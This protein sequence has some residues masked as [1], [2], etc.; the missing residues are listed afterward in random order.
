METKLHWREGGRRSWNTKH[1]TQRPKSVKAVYE[2]YMDSSCSRFSRPDSNQT[3]DHYSR[4][5]NDSRD[6]LIIV[7]RWVQCTRDALVILVS[8][9]THPLLRDFCEN[10]A[11]LTVSLSGGL[12]SCL[13]WL[14]FLPWLLRKRRFG[15]KLRCLRWDFLSPPSL[16]SLQR[17]WDLSGQGEMEG[18]VLRRDFEQLLWQL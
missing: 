3:K 7:S 9:M 1:P 15:A 8:M 2:R 10:D 6:P 5:E 16:M 18:K 11:L 17:K 13:L 4:Q 12:F 14:P